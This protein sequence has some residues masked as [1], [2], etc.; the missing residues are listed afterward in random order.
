MG[1][2]LEID[3]TH[4]FHRLNGCSGGKWETK[5]S[6]LYLWWD[7]GP[8]EVLR[9]SCGGKMFINHFHADMGNIFTL[10]SS[11][12]PPSW[13]LDLFLAR[14]DNGRNSENVSTN[15]NVSNSFCKY[16]CKECAQQ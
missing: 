6:Q 5:G 3:I 13:F 14:P 1:D 10:R 16:D 7:D 2:L 15:R 8:C 9:G 4:R 11:R 12:L